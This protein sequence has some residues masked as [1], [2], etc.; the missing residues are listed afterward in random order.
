MGR[1]RAISYGGGRQSTALVVLGARGEID[2]PLAIFANVGDR[3]ENPATL[4]YLSDHIMPWAKD[5]PIEIIQRR[6]VDRTG[7]ERDLYDDTTSL[8]TRTIPIPVYMEGGAPGTRQCTD[9]YKIAVVGRECRRRGAS[10]RAPALIA[11][12]FSMD[13]LGRVSSRH[14]APWEEPVY[15]LLDLRLTTQDCANIIASEGLPPAPKSSCWFCPFKRPQRWAEERRDA[16]EIFEA[17]VAM[18]ER[19]NDKRALFGKDAVFLTSTR[20]PLALLTEAQPALFAGDGPETCD[21][22]YCWT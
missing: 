20:R 13:E 1:V 10:K 3:A 5:K 6:W 11:V 7:K 18:E 14:A 22:G 15:P 19:I 12:G 17:G 4:R 8:E 16:P 2:F 21:D 9:R